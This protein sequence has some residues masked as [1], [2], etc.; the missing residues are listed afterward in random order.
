MSLC[1]PRK[2]KAKTLGHVEE[3]SCEDMDE[4]SKHIAK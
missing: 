1:Y 4:S 3:R 2:Q